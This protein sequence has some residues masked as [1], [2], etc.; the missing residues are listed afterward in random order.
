MNSEQ[1]VDKL[2]KC[3]GKIDIDK[4]FVLEAISRAT[5]MILDQTHKIKELEDQVSDRGCFRCRRC[6]KVRSSLKAE[7]LE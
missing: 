7:K 2:R 4:G 3:K 5:A 6:Q 1:L